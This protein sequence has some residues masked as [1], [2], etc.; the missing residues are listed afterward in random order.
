MWE[1]AETIQE[2][3]R[4]HV[5]TPV[6]QPASLQFHSHK[7]TKEVLLLTA[8]EQ[9]LFHSLCVTVLGIILSPSMQQDKEEGLFVAGKLSLL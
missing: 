7:C 6:P 5:K 9:R 3:S 4:K 8:P 1:S 2:K